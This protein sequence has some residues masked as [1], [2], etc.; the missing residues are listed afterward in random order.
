MSRRLAKNIP[1]YFLNP[2]VEG[3]YPVIP[4]PPTPSH[5]VKPLY[6]NNP[7]PQ[8]GLYDA[9]SVPHNSE[10]ILSNTCIN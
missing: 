3:K 1:N 2:L 8:F 5:I 4:P 7:K 10:T 6:V 9:P